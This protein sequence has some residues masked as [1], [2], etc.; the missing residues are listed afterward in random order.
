MIPNF[1][2]NA[3]QRCCTVAIGCIVAL[4]LLTGCSSDSSV[5]D[6]TGIIEPIV[7]SDKGSITLDLSIGIN[8]G[9]DATTRAFTPNE[10]DPF[11]PPVSDYEKVHTLRVVIVRHKVNQNG[12]EDLIIEHNRMVTVRDGYG[13]VIDNQYIINDNLQFKVVADEKKTI[14]LFANEKGVNLNKPTDEKFD[15]TKDL[16]VGKPFPSEKVNNLLI[17]RKTNAAFIDNGTTTP[18]ADKCYV[19]MSESF[20]VIVPAATGKTE[21]FYSKY[22][23]LNSSLIKF[24]FSFTL[25]E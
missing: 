13:D 12:T 14:Y 8:N 1:I 24:S 19:P 21:D 23:F 9:S 15:F 20:D 3:L 22:I 4:P 2:K 17:T 7:E 10:N 11:E 16:I 5:P 25:K 18:L 6:N